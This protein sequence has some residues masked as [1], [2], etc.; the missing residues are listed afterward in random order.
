MDDDTVPAG[1]PVGTTYEEEIAQLDV[2]NTDAVTP[3]VTVKEPE[4]VLLSNETNPF[5]TTN[6]LAI[7]YTGKESI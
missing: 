2:P 1:R 3:P 4:I 7:S 6:S 5:C